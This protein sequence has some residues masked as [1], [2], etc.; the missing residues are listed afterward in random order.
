[1]LIQGKSLVLRGL[2]LKVFVFL[3]LLTGFMQPAAAR[4]EI[5]S[6]VPPY[7]ISPSQ[8]AVQADFG[9]CD[10]KDGL[11]RIGLQF[12]TPNW[13]GTIKYADHEWYTPTDADVGWWRSWCT[14][15]NIQCLLTIYNNTG[16]WDWNLARSAFAGNRQTFVNE[17]VSEMERLSLDGIDID[18]EGIGNLDDD[19]AAFDLFIQELSAELK[20]RGKVLT[21]DSFHYIW[22]APNQ[23]WWPDWLGEV[24]N[25]HAMGYEDLYEGGSGYQK[26]SFQQNTGT[27]AGYAGNAVL[28]GM[29]S[30]VSSWGV[31]S[32]RGTSALAHVR[33]VRN[34]LFSGA[35]GIAI[36]DLQLSAWQDSDLWCEIAELKDAG[37]NPPPDDTTPPNPN[38]MDWSVQPYLDTQWLPD[39]I[40]GSMTAATATDSSGGVQYFFDCIEAPPGGWWKGCEDSGW[41]GSA[42]FSDWYLE[43]D[44]T[45]HYRVKAR[46]L[47][48]NETA[49]SDE[50]IITL[51]TP[52]NTAPVANDDNTAT[53]AGTSVVIAV[54]DNDTDQDGDTLDIISFDGV[55]NG[56]VVDNANILTYTPDTG[57]TGTEMFTYTISDG[58]GGNDT[59]T[60]TVQVTENTVEPN[61]PFGQHLVS[62]AVGTILPSHRSQAQLD[63]DV[64][65]FY[66]YWKTNY[67]V[68]AGTT[69]EGNPLYRVTFGSGD[70]GTTVSEGQGFGM[71]L[72]PL[73]AGY[74]TQAQV[75]FNG[76]WEFSR[77]HPSSTDSRLMDWKVPETGGDNS[78]FDGDADI[79]YGLLLADAQWGSGGWID[80]ASDAATVITG[81]LESTIGPVSRLPMLGDWVSANGSPYNQYTP[82]SSDFMPGH[83]RAYG[84][85]TNDPLWDQ[86]INS[87]QSVIDSIQTNYSSATGLLPDFIVDADGSSTPA[88]GNFLEGANDGR[89]YYNAGRDPWRIGVDALL[90]DD[91]ASLAQVRKIANWIAGSTGGNPFN[92][93]AGYHLDGTPLGNYFTTFFVSPMGI[94]AMTEPSLQ[95][96]LNDIYDSVYNTHEGYYEDS[97]NLL[98][99]L[100][101]TGNYWDPT[102]IDGTGSTPPVFL[103]D[104]VIKSNATEDTAYNGSILGDAFDEDGDALTFSKIS[105]PAWLTVAGNGDLSGTPANAEVGINNWTVEVNDGNGGSDQATLQITVINTNDAPF[106]TSNPIAKPDATENVAYNN[107]LTGDASDDDGDTLVFSKLSGPAWLTVSSNG[108]LSGIPADADVG[109]NSWTVEVSDGNGGSDTTVVTITVAAPVP[110]APSGLTATVQTSG[111]GKNKTKDVTLNWNDNSNNEEDF[112]IERC[113]E[114]GKGRNKVCYF[115]VLGGVAANL[116]TFSDSPG[117]GTFKYRVKAS[118]GNGDSGYSNEVKI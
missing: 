54:L 76:L 46:D 16:S 45:Y 92:I 1:M 17:L 30:Y 10:A 83:F 110:Q 62:Y 84:R 20:H 95:P 4:N 31:S 105:G 5:I 55:S 86:V 103:T 97:V 94:A 48:G 100:V 2:V 11:T 58:N 87:T 113:Q 9:A 13:D 53:E 8:A 117:S 106:F 37:T 59:A 23:S 67:L 79:A 38:P 102:T 70:P 39:Y 3:P 68:T 96:F 12:W 89:Y 74:D 28:M 34:D 33:E 47:Y 116:T 72:V 93:K 40:V 32:G 41:Q 75:I 64:R 109:T 71:V 27:A 81:I 101:M 22:N 51:G 73:M 77:N 44:N 42:T 112:V 98:S 24:D 69:P 65:A 111:K 7:A 80:Y 21:I 18:L 35:T 52:A 14:S 29:P 36:W 49:W 118:N 26:Y 114:T 56:V 82:R 91:A 115:S 57:F 107:T 50:A 19:R 66:D 60:V 85:A 43:N 6:W 88:P 15:N 63:N 25:I 90:N 104:P 108:L 61:Y 99:L 78:A